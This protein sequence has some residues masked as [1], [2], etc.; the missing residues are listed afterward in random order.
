MTHYPEYDHEFIS[1]QMSLRAPQA[2]SLTILNRIMGITNLSKDTSPEE[3][4]REITVLY[5]ICKDFERAFP[6]ITFALATGVGKTKLMGA[7]VTYLYTCHGI[8]NFFVLAPN[9]TIYN[10]LID[11]FDKPDNPKYVFGGLDCFS[12]KKPRV[13]TGDTYRE[14]LPGQ[15]GLEESVNINIFNIGKINAEMRKDNLPLIK[16]LSEYIGQS[17]FDYLASCEDLVILMD[18]SHHYRADR[19]MAVINELRPLLGLELT[20]TP[21]V[22]KG[23]KTIKFKNVVY[24]YSLA[25]AIVDGYVKEPAAATRK[26]FNPGNYNSVELDRLKLKDAIRLHRA[27][28][29][30]LE[31]YAVNEGAKRVLP[32]VLVVCRDTDHANEIKDY[33][34]STDFFDGYYTDKTIEV[35]SNQRGQEKDENV[36]R[37]VGLERDDNIV[38]IVIHVNMLKEGWDVTNLYTIVPL[39]AASSQTLIEQTIG[40]GLRLPFGK[41][42]GNVII[43]RVTVVAHERFDKLIEE[44]NNESSI[45]RAE[46]IITIED[47]DDS[48]KDKESVTA[49]THYQMH[50][51]EMENKLHHA[52]SDER[53]EEIKQEIAVTRAVSKAIDEVMNQPTTPQLT[54][55]APAVLTPLSVQPSVQATLRQTPQQEQIT[56]AT[57]PAPVTTADLTK[58]EVKNRIIKQAKHNLVAQGQLNL[59]DAETELEQRIESVFQPLIEQR[60]RSTIDIPDIALIPKIERTYGFNDF[61]LQFTNIFTS[62]RVPPE[63]L[64]IETLQ[65]NKVSV[66]NDNTGEVLTDTLEDMI[67][68]E[69]LNIGDKIAYNDQYDSLWHKLIRQALAELH[70]NMTDEEVI[71]T[72]VHFKKEL[73][74]DIYTQIMLP[75]HFY[76][77]DPEFEVRRITN[78]LEIL[79]NGYTKY[80]QDQITDYTKT[81]TAYEL[82]NRIF[83][84]YKKACHTEYKFD[85]VPEHTLSIVLDKG[86]DDVIKW[87]RPAPKQFKIWYRGGKLYEPDFIVETTDTVYMVEVKSSRDMQDEDVILKAK[88]AQL[89]CEHVNEFAAKSW[90]YVLIDS[91]N[92]KRSSTFAVL[93]R[94][95]ARNAF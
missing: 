54:Q 73:A 35:H 69:L 45:I 9:L 11:D 88:A 37:L 50:I 91:D 85:S 66:L 18:E 77:N 14:Q 21:Q 82:R 89:Y 29:A 70:K 44:A 79:P 55:I 90:S 87:L 12:Q 83:G 33:I 60:I 28:K 25:K 56:P 2:E 84:G 39:R 5:P 30:E 40:R 22:E 61:D 6:S 59:V 1:E 65:D 24:E 17:Y 48:E 31:A 80:R 64:H 3:L 10:K 74:R 49:K 47:D 63:T 8:R 52:R 67:L 15:M 92:I 95:S 86:C 16:R 81:V 19:G 43:D 68:M 27:T 62:Y 57:A 32:F 93:V 51:D 38:E 53:K 58:E 26:D 4:L 36:T 78:V 76:L 20:A 13:I 75:E 71:K 7:F 72:V 94:D 34:T 42:T 46:N 23:T 41:R